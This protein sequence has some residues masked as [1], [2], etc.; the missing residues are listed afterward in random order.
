MILVSLVRYHHVAVEC[1]WHYITMAVSITGTISLAV[2]VTGTISLHEKPMGQKL[3][4]YINTL[5]VEKVS[6]N[7]HFT[8]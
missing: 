2:S 4:Y 7:L 5:V 8:F 1:H 3:L 6:G